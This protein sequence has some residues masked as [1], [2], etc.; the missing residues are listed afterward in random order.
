M[1]ARPE[2]DVAEQ[3]RALELDE[4]AV[5]RVT[6]TQRVE[7]RGNS[8]GHGA[9]QR[10]KRRTVAGR[11]VP[12]IPRGQR[13]ARLRCCDELDLGAVGELHVL[14]ANAVIVRAAR[15]QRKTELSVARGRLLEVRDR[16]R[17]VIQA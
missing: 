9:V 6:L 16:N 15:L 7:T 3:S 10:E 8:I 14:V 5:V 13:I 11:E 1:V 17:D 12:A 4:Y 2:E